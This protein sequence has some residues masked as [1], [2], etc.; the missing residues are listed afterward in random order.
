MSYLSEVLADN[1]LFYWRLGEAAGTTAADASYHGRLGTYASSGVTYSATGAVTGN[2][3]VTTDGAS[4]YVQSTA[5][6]DM[7]LYT[8]ITI[9]MWA[10]L[11]AY[12]NDD[13]LLM[14]L[15]VGDGASG[16]L[17][18]NPHSSNGRFVIAH[19]KVS[20]NETADYARTD[21]T[22]GSYHHFVFHFSTTV[23]ISLRLDKVTLTQF[24]HSGTPSAPFASAK[25]FNFCAREGGVLQL[26]A[27][28]DEIAIYGTALSDA[29]TDA[30]YDASAVTSAVYTVINGTEAQ[31][32]N[33][34]A[35]GTDV[36]ALTYKNGIT[37]TNAEASVLSSTAG[38]YVTPD[39][40]R[41]AAATQLKRAIA[42][43]AQ[44]VST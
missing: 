33:V 38:V 12:A 26:P 13:K 17:F 6:I 34:N 43:A 24:S 15:G 25:K 9:E 16:D 31:L 14:E 22:T 11:G 28:I 30:H 35:G 20:G 4:G 23:N 3:A 10:N 39:L 44:Y 32:V 37:L 2:T 19:F 29:R 27:T 36:D 42:V 7:S 40:T 1:P 21:I 5:N 8:D 41:V 18:V